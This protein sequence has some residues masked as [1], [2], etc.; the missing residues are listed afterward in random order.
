MKV[1]E[2]YSL[3]NNEISRLKLE[4]FIE[5][6]YEH[7]LINIYDVKQS[8]IIGFGGAFT[9]TSAYNYSLLNKDN[10]NKVLK[11][12]FSKGGLN[13][14]LGRICIGS[15]DFY[16]KERSYKNSKKDKF[17]IEGDKKY[18]IPFILD[19]IKYRK[20]DLKFLASPWSPPAYMKENNER[21]Y[22]GRLR[23]DCYEEYAKYICDFLVAY[24]KEG[25]KIDYLTIQNEPKARQTW[26]SCNFTTEEEI[27]FAKVL[28]KELKK[29]KI[30]I[31][32][33]CWD[34]NKERMVEKA[35][36]ALKDNLFKGIGYHWYSGDHFDAVSVTRKLFPN[37]LILET[38]FCKTSGIDKTVSTYTSE[39][40][41]GIRCGA[42]G[43]I[44]WN[45][46]TDKNGG[47]Y[48]DRKDGCLAPLTFI[49]KNRISKSTNY[50]Q[51]WIYSHFIEKDAV[52]LYTS[53][54]DERVKVSAVR[55]KNGSIVVNILN[56]YK[57]EDIW[58]YFKNKFLKVSC[59]KNASYTIVIK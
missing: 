47:P 23:K 21:L 54:Y 36:K 18:I 10:K 45:L 12:L 40:I 35:S 27:S 46:L 41:N 3:L 51:T 59:K 7:P 43:F 13:Y 39:Y 5:G 16:L 11:E 17:S 15:S 37:K 49:Q 53:S 26:E 20:G 24:K 22:G 52:S 4:G 31:Q 57:D 2:S 58:L 29:R 9:E 38:E 8:N 56:N 30:N 25:I 33:L 19:A 55:N 14:N 42:N 28:K 48:H 34:H 44:E 50:Y 1:I 6:K 32:L